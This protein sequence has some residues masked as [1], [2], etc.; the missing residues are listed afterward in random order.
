MPTRKPDPASIKDEPAPMPPTGI[1]CPKCGGIALPSWST[2]RR[3]RGLVRVRRCKSC[4]HKVRTVE[5]I[6]SANG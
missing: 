5:S 3:K 6:E 2:R 1:A 4:N